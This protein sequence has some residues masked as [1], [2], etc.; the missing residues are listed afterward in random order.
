MRFGRCCTAVLYRHVQDGH[1]NQ[2]WRIELRL[3]LKNF[4]SN[5]D[6]NAQSGTTDYGSML[7]TSTSRIHF[8]ACPEERISYCMR[9]WMTP[10]T[11]SFGWDLNWRERLG[12]GRPSPN[13]LRCEAFLD[14]QDRFNVH[15]HQCPLYDLGSGYFWQTLNNVVMQWTP[16][17][18]VHYNGFPMFCARAFW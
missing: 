16:R 8:L 15:V 11:W 4:T 14:F 1:Q 12:N 10:L 9:K 5:G 2:L 3:P 7:F 13:T 18:F 6:L 17:F